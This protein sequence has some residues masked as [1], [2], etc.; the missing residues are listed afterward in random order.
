MGDGSVA[1]GVT[2]S[3]FGNDAAD[4]TTFATGDRALG[5]ASWFTPLGAGADLTLSAWDLY[6]ASGQLIGGPS[7]W[8]NVSNV[9]VAI[10]FHLGD[11]YVQPS[12][13]GRVWAADGANAGK[14]ANFGVRLRF[15]TGPLSF[16]PAVSYGVGSLNPIGGGA[17]VDLTGL[18]AT[19]IVRLH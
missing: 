9:N 3:K 8:E 10:G 2:Y 11:V 7:P 1:L 13:E 12:A 6:R 15:A 18:R 5:Q 14:L 16:N 19:L 4:S 17:S